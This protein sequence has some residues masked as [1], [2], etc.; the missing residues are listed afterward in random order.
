M[1]GNG[2][3]RCPS[4]CVRAGKASF[5][6]QYLGDL[7][8]I[9]SKAAPP[10]LLI[11]GTMKVAMMR[12]AE[13]DGELVAHPAAQRPPLGEPEIV[14]IAGPSAHKSARGRDA[15]GGDSREYRVGRGQ[16]RVHSQFQSKRSGNRR[17]CHP[18]KPPPKSRSATGPGRRAATSP[19]ARA[20]SAATGTTR[21]AS[22]D[23]RRR[24]EPHQLR[25]SESGPP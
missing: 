11:A 5:L 24:I 22:T 7:D 12:A 15:A 1:T 17:F 20:R 8:Q 2:G 16:P 4:R 14:R 6:S 25:T 21:T 23:R 10:R 13:R 18:R 19:V 3:G 9:R